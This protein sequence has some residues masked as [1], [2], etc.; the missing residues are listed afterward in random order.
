MERMKLLAAEQTRKFE[1]SQ[2]DQRQHAESYARGMEEA[3]KRR[4]EDAERRRRADEDRRRLDDERARNRERKL[5]AMG[6]KEGGWDEGKLEAQ[7]EEDRRGFRGA[8]GG[9]RGVRR[10]GGL[11]GSRYAAREGDEVPDV[12]RFLDDRYRGDRGGRGGRGAGRG[13]PGRGGAG[14]G[15]GRQ[16]PSP[17]GGKPA[18]AAAPSLGTDDFPAL[19]SDGKKPST[20]SAA[21]SSKAPAVSTPPAL[22]TPPAVGKWDDEMEAMDELNEQQQQQG[23]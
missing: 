9:V 15:G 22:P 3:R 17:A 23:K 7:E 4:A 2:K 6:A 20:S 11:G 1:M 21:D 5:K 18:N 13:G 19:P 14:R 16:Q 12:D 10:E 8:N